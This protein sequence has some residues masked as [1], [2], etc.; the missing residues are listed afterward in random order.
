M[1]SGLGSLQREILATLDEAKRDRMG[2]RGFKGESVSPRYPDNWPP[3]HRWTFPGWVKVGRNTSG[4]AS[5]STT[6]APSA[7]SWRVVTTSSSWTGYQAIVRRR[8]LASSGD[9]DQTRIAESHPERAFD[10]RL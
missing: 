3:G 4:L 2:Y 10:C 5:T 1:S 7:R 6:C 8:I 9:A